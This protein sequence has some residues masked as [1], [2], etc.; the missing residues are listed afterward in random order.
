[1]QNSTNIGFIGAGLMGHGLAKNIARAGFPM[2]FLAHPGNRPVGDLLELGAW[3]V[4]SLREITEGSDVIVMCVTGSPQVR[5]I[6]AGEEGLLMTLAPG[7]VVVDCS[8]VEP[9]V[10][11]AVARQV[12]D[13]GAHYLDAPLTRTP[14]EA[15]LGKVNVMVGGEPEVLARVRPVL[16]T[17]AE[18]VY[19]AG[20]TGAGATLKLLHNYISLGNCV[21]LAEAAVA[22]RM[23]DVDIGTFIEVLTTGGGDSTALKRLAPY[24]TEGDAGALSFS[25]ANAAKDTG[26]YRSLVSHLGAP[27]DAADA[28]SR[29]FARAREEGLGDSPVP[30]I[31][32]YFSKQGR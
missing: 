19:H 32:E 15:E 26:Y 27:A 29:V 14:R 30:E 28:I 25:I 31:I 5:E 4:D 12:Q 9:R 21:L 7:A 11:Q 2:V 24:I 18:N 3:S 22:A 23:S 17:F 16:D 1:M 10:S 6:V 13:A 8:T 20:P